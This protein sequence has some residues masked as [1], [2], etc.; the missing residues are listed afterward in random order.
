[1]GLRFWGIAG[2]ENPAWVRENFAGAED[3]LIN[4]L[5]FLQPH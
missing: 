3:S 1:M 4:M 2:G 5:P